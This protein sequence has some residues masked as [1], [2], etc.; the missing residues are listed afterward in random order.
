M[1]SIIYAIKA[2]NPLSS[3]VLYNPLSMLSRLLILYHP[4]F[5]VMPLSMLSRLPFSVINVLYHASIDAIKAANP[6][7]SNVLCPQLSMLSRLLILYHPMFCIIPLPMSRLIIL[8]I[9]VNP[10]NP[11]TNAREAQ[12]PFPARSCT[13]ASITGMRLVL[14]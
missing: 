1:S 13:I 12:N 8:L 10:L 9:G 2:T 4:M 5:Y 14:L 7:S 11:Q 3:N 6:L